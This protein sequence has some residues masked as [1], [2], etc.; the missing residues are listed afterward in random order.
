MNRRIKKLAIDYLTYPTGQTW[1]LFKAACD[2]AGLDPEP[3]LES[4]QSH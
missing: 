2:A 3:I 4:L 1:Q